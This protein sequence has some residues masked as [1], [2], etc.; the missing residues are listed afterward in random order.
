MTLARS[1][2]AAEPF[3]LVGVGVRRR[4]LDGRRQVE[5]EPSLGRRADDV[6]HRLADLEREIELGPG[7]A[8]RRIFELKI[9][10]GRGLGQRF[11]LLRRGD[12]DLGHAPAVGAEDD[13]ALQGRGRIVEVEDDLLRALD[14]LERALDQLRPALGQHL[15][16]DAVG[17]RARLDDRA[18]EVEIGLRRGGKG[19]LDLLEAHM[20]QEA[21]HPVLAVDAHRLDQRLVAVAQID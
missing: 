12:R 8:L 13:L 16:S 9:R 11:H 7:E 3:E 18:D 4:H 14:R 10:A 1:E 6:L 21:E 5:D 15:D 20:R 17:D 19:D 2:C